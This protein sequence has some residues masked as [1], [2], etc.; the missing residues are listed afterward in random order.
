MTSIP[1]AFSAL[2]LSVIASVGE[3]FTKD[4][5]GDSKAAL[6][7]FSRERSTHDACIDQAHAKSIKYNP[8]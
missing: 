4:I 8:R 1:L 5:R 6:I 3:G 2:A 7:Y